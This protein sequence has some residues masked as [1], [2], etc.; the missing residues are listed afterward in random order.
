[1][2][3]YDSFFQKNKKGY[4]S[5]LLDTPVPFDATKT[6][7]LVNT[8]K[9]LPQASRDVTNTF[10]TNLVQGFLKEGAIIGNKVLKGDINASFTPQ[11]RVGKALYGTNEPIS[12]TSVGKEA[13]FRDASSP[14]IPVLDPLIGGVITSI[15][16]LSA[17]ES[18]VGRE[19]LFKSIKKAYPIL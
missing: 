10:G 1:M 18:K 11:G 6:G 12:L 3:G 2:A 9:G 4:D 16:L 8:I 17:G 19:S 5:A 13:S 15:D 7:V 14:T